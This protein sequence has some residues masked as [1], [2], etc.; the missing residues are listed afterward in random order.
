MKLFTLKQLSKIYPVFTESS[1]RWLRFNGEENGFNYCVI[2]IGKRIFIDINRFEN[3]L[4]KNAVNGEAN[5]AEMIYEL[6]TND[7]WG[8]ALPTARINRKAFLKVAKALH[9]EQF[10][11]S[12]LWDNEKKIEDILDEILRHV[13]GVLFEDMKDGRFVLKLARDDYNPDLIPKYSPSNIIKLSHFSRSAWDETT[14]EVKITYPS[15]T[16]QYKLQTAQA[17]D[18]ANRQIQGAVVSVTQNYP[19]ITRAELANRIA[20]RDL[21]SL[22]YP[23]S[24][25]N[26][27][28]NRDAKDLHP[29]DVFKLD[30]P[31][32]GIG[33]L[34]MRVNRINYGEL[35]NNAISVD[36]IQDIFSLSDSIYSETPESN[37]LNPIGEPQN[38]TIVKIIKMPDF[39]ITKT[40]MKPMILAVRPNGQTIGYDIMVKVGYGE[41]QFEGD[42]TDWTPTALLDEDYSIDAVGGILITTGQDLDIVQ[43]TGNSEDN[44]ILVGDEWIRFKNIVISD[45]KYQLTGIDRGLS[46]T[47]IIDHKSSDRVWF[48]MYGSGTTTRD[49][50]FD[51][52]LRFKLLSQTLNEKLI[53]T[54]ATAYQINK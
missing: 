46:N 29:G 6:L 19:G 43:N 14:N 18:L 5:A 32:L 36:A 40:R 12:L 4:S 24:K 8:M 30:W 3:W 7:R 33:A 50:A 25:C 26:L 42:E 52:R 49:Y 34:L 47:D 9:D 35:Q 27:E 13:D 10:G 37:W 11:L 39:D 17:Q 45:G 28:I 41:Y 21:K 23:L 16:H 48:P 22:S 44:L 15:S 51:E 38:I 31:D 1:L 54:A 2:K 53:I 20:W